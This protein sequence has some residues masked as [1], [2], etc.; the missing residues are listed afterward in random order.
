VPDVL[1]AG[2]GIIGCA[3]ATYLLRADP[4]LEVTVVEPD[5]GYGLAATPRAS[6]GVRQL[7]T[8]PEN[9]LLS[10]YT[11]EVIAEW[12]EFARTSEPPPD[13]G[14]KQHGYLFIGKPEWT[15]TL[16]ENLATQHAH[17]VIAEWLEP[18]EVA[19]RYPALHVDDLGPAVLSPNDGWLDPYAFLTGFARL[20]K[21]LGAKMVRDRVA[22]VAVSSATVTAVRLASGATMAAQAVV[23]AAGCWAAGLAERAGMPLPVEPM[24]R[25]E[26]Y[27]EGPVGL[28][29]Y[30]FI[31]DP[32]GLAIRPEGPGVSAGLVD[33]THP[34]GFDLSIDNTYFERRV[35][36]AL[37]HR[38]PAFDR[39]ALRAT[40]VGLYDQN[41]LDGNMILGNWPGHLD[42]LYVA[43]G[44]SGHGMMHAPGVGRALSELILHGRYQTLDLTA[45]GYERIAAGRAYPETG[46]K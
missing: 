31:K 6:G 30:P 22:D 8:R 40:T 43:T 3:T 9:I 37:A 19:E 35:W 23:D 14:W 29:G 20:A 17:G 42:N 5:P 44:F 24:R 45:M 18:A 2:G 32:A 28:D 41:R 13:L 10:R 12:A 34:G 21:T 11:L 7:F 4:S 38:V 46:I 25:F 16:R 36:P 26:H 15:G 1:I 39:A 33:F 27:V